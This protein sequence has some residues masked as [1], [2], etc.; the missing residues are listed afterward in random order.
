MPEVGEGDEL[1]AHISTLDYSM[2]STYV[3]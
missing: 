3:L 2:V 1:S